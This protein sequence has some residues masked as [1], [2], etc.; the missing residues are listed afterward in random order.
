MIVDDYILAS[1]SDSGLRLDLA[2]PSCR[3]K[4]RVALTRL[5]GRFAFACGAHSM[6]GQVQ[7]W[8]AFKAEALAK[9]EEKG[10]A[11]VRSS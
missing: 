4:H 9:K 3:L 8:A 11:H 7:N 1:E 5:D 6:T 2:C 10:D